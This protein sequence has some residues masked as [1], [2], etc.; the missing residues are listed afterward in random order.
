MLKFNSDD[1][2]P[3]APLISAGLFVL[4]ARQFLSL[5]NSP[6]VETDTAVEATKWRR[7]DLADR[8][9]AREITCQRVVL[10]PVQSPAVGDD[11][12]ALAQNT[13]T[14]LS[15][16]KTAGLGDH[17]VNRRSERRV[18]HLFYV[19]PVTIRISLEKL[20]REHHK[21]NERND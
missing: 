1:R 6:T 3:T 10:P 11:G 17:V 18:A 15:K 16:T 9:L 5:D 13:V 12:E 19:C 14:L 20:H 7:N 8:D 4:I 2:R 21:N